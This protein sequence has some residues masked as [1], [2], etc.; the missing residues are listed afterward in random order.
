[1]GREGAEASPQHV[2]LLALGQGM[3]HFKDPGPLDARDAIGAAIEP[4]A[5]EHDLVHAAL[6]RRPEE[7]IDVSRPSNHRA[8]GPSPAPVNERPR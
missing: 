8:P 6:E 3:V 4:R 5:E 7:I 2:L 1:M